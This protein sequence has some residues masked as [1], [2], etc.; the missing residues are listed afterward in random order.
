MLVEQKA[1]VDQISDLQDPAYGATV[2]LERIELIPLVER[3]KIASQRHTTKI[4]YLIQRGLSAGATGHQD[5]TYSSLGPM[6]S[7]SWPMSSYCRSRCV[8]SDVYSTPRGTLVGAA[9]RYSGRIV[10]YLSPSTALCISYSF[11]RTS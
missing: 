8:F 3:P 5:Y 10:K 7:R 1:R 4:E 11:T 6:L 9:G 2:D